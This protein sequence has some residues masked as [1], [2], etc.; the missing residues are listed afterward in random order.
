MLASN[1][2]RTRLPQTLRTAWA[3]FAAAGFSAAGCTLITDVDRSKIAAEAPPVTPA[4][5]GGNEMPI[6]EEPAPETPDAAIEDAAVVPEPET[7]SDAGAE[8]LDAAP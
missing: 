6:D 5:A 7:P 4:D 3:L 8:E 2:R 1:A